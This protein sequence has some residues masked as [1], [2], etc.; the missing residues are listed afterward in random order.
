MDYL[1]QHKSPYLPM[2]YL[3]LLYMSS[4]IKPMRS[5]LILRNGNNNSCTNTH[6]KNKAI[7]DNYFHAIED[8]K[9]KDGNS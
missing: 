2:E 6:K 3:I 9:Q 5:S 1:L 7:Q 8:G 4:Y